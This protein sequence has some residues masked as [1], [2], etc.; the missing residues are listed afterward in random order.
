MRVQ[1]QCSILNLDEELGR[2]L[3]SI[4]KI[5]AMK[6]E[7]CFRKIFQAGLIHRLKGTGCSRVSALLRPSL[8]SPHVEIDRPSQEVNLCLEPRACRK[9]ALLDGEGSSQRGLE[10]KSLAF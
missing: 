4:V 6:T 5:A 2:A 10:S 1:V 3:R 7:N 9:A 8:D